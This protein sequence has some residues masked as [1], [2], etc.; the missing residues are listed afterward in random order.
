MKLLAFLSMLFIFSACTPK[1]VND[2]ATAS[3][4]QLCVNLGKAWLYNHSKVRAVTLAEVEKRNIN[5]EYCGKVAD[6]KIAELGSQLKIQLCEQVANLYYQGEYAGYKK[7]MNELIRLGY[8]D[9][10]CETIAEFYWRRVARKQERSAR[11]AAAFKAAADMMHRQQEKMNALGTWN[12]PI[13]I[14]VR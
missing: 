5:K 3:D 11:F 14:N 10:E 7:K 6:R 1:Y 8:V 2:T 4:E 12:N 9:E 13:Y